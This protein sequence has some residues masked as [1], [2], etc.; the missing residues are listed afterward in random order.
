VPAIGVEKAIRIWY[1][2]N[3][4]IFTAST[5]FEQAKAWTIQ[6]ASALGYDSATQ[7]A[8]KLAWEA[9]GVGVSISCTPLTN[10]V[11]VTGISGASGSS[12]YYCIDV[13]A[14]RASSFVMSGGTGD[15]DLYVRLGAAPTLSTYNCRPYLSGNSETCNLAAQTAD[16]RIYILLYGY[17][18]YSGTSLK[19]TY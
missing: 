15:A 4:D 7:D 17:A 14:G 1:K 19:A 2:A 6:A 16:Q 13:P 5:T 12:K 10:G 3:T 11:A 18:S 8:V 9:V